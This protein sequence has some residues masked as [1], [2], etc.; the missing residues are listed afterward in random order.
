[1]ELLTDYF[2]T[3]RKYAPTFL[4]TFEFRGAPVTQP[5]LDALGCCAS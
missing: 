4:E 1:M 5:L 3:L 2:S